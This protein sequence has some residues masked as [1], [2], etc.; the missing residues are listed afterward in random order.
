MTKINLKSRCALMQKLML[1]AAALPA[2]ASISAIAAVKSASDQPLTKLARLKQGDLISLIAPAG[3]MTDDKIQNAVKRPKSNGFKVRVDIN[4]CAAH[5]GYAGTVRE[6]LD[7]FSA[8][9]TD[10][11]EKGV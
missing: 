2:L 10:K 3:V 9:F 6:R 8:A 1:A 4:I 5:G 7:G 11:D